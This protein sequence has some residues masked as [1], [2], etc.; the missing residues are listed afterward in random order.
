MLVLAMPVEEPIRSVT[1]PMMMM[2]K[3]VPITVESAEV[4]VSKISAVVCPVEMS[5]ANPVMAMLKAARRVIIRNSPTVGEA[6]RR[7]YEQTDQNG[8]YKCFHLNTLL[9]CLLDVCDVSSFTACPPSVV[10][11]ASPRFTLLSSLDKIAPSLNVY[12][13]PFSPLVLV[14][15]ALETFAATAGAHAVRAGD[16]LHSVA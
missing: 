11:W 12:V 13:A 15:G 5:R 2:V 3:P 14:C 8:Q 9:S 4:P 7:S 1:I 6:R 16:T 10:V